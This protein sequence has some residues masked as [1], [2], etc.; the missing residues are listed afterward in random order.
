MYVLSG[1]IFK[2]QKL[3]K[4]KKRY[5]WNPLPKSMGIEIFG[6]FWEKCDISGSI[7]L[8]GHVWAKK[9]GK[10][11]RFKLQ[12]I[13]KIWTTVTAPVFQFLP[14]PEPGFQYISSP[15]LVRVS[16]YFQIPEPGLLKSTGFWP[17]PGYSSK[18][19]SDIWLLGFILKV[20]TFCILFI[21]A[22]FTEIH[23]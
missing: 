15:G 20:R 13:N 21:C 19:G 17:G 22:F 16:P 3:T 12:I 23:I 2:I 4:I 8:V 6:N 14:G 9:F 7:L 11:T 5:R 10:Y 1:G 18:K